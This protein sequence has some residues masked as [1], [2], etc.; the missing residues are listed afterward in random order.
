MPLPKNKYFKKASRK[1]TD[2]LVFGAFEYK[3]SEGFMSNVQ[4]LFTTILWAVTF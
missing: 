2:V 4:R 1:I 3:A